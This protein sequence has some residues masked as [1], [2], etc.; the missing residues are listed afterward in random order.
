VPLGTR[1]IVAYSVGVTPIST[2]V[3]VLARDTTRVRM[4]FGQP[5]I[6]KGMRT[7]ATPGVHVMAQEF[8]VRR[9]GGAGYFV[10]STAIARYPDFINAFNDVPGVRMARRIGSVW[11]TMTN[12]KGTSCTPTILLDGI[13]VTGNTLSDLQSHEV[14]AFEVY[15]RPLMVPAQLLPPGRLP[16][17]GLVVVW[18]KYT[19]RNR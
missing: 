7:S 13:D 9:L 1:Q 12:D 18:T 5:I 10:D 2:T 3:D 15:A 11:L 8:D 17:C 4:Q 6:L 19:F 16:E 14:A